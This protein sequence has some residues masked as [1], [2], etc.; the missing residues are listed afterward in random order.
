MA[1]ATIQLGSTG[2][3]VAYLR[4]VFS[5]IGI[6]PD[7]SVADP[8]LF[9]AWLNTQVRAYQSLHGI[10]VDGIVGPDTWATLEGQPLPSNTG[11]SSDSQLP[12]PTKSGPLIIDDGGSATAAQSKST[13]IMWVLGGMGLLLLWGMS[14][15][16]KRS[17]SSKKKSLR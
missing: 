17:S 14:S 11:S 9:D 8:N 2:S 4:D 16:S 6:V 5:N 7:A 13:A 12:D 3:D 15:G 1:H 10:K